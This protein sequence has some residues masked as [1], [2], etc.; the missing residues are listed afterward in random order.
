MQVELPPT[1]LTRSAVEANPNIRLVDSDIDN[2]IQLFCYDT[3]DDNSEEI[4]KLSRG[5]VFAGDNLILR[6]FPYTYEYTEKDN[7]EQID[8]LLNNNICSMYDSF[9]GSL[10]RMFFYNNKWY[11]STNRKLDASRSKWSSKTSFGEFFHKALLY[12]FH[13]SQPFRTALGCEVMPSEE[14][15]ADY[16]LNKFFNILDQRKQYMFLLL[17]NHENRIV[18]RYDHPKFLHV[19][20]FIGE[21]LFLNQENIGLDY[22]KHHLFEN[23]EQ[24]YDYV[25]TLDWTLLQGIIVFAPGNTQYKIW[26]QTYADLYKIR[27]NESSIKF[28]YLQL[29]NDAVKKEA[30]CNL[31]PECRDTFLFYEKCI[32][33]I[34]QSILDGYVNRYIK[35]NFTTLPLEQFII[36]SE[37]HKWHQLDRE[38]NRVNLTIINEMIAKQQPTS[39]NRMIKKFIAE[40]R[41]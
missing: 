39:I 6:G 41:K 35:K 1:I 3:C 19:G 13:T 30:L 32:I 23:I 5:V 11:L 8:A 21:E 28:R 22:P 38:N 34:S 29:R 31:Y 26:N 27:G 40:S 16:V 9:E 18:C 12:E 14:V 17:N 37:V 7:K 20:T 4:V 10:L 36:M 33:D 15:D 24:M 25:R 2:N